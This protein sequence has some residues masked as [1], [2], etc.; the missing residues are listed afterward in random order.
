MIIIGTG[1][2]SSVRSL[3]GILVGDGLCGGASEWTISLKNEASGPGI[4]ALG[5]F[6]HTAYRGVIRAREEP[7]YDPDA[8]PGIALYRG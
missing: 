2:T 4:S 5:Y 6:L 8:I 7:D 1:I 3:D